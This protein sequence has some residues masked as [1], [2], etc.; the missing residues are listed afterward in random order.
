[1][2]SKNSTRHRGL[3]YL[4]P[5]FVG[6]DV[7]GSQQSGGAMAQ[8]FPQRELERYLAGSQTPG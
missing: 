8:D 2:N 4:G 3:V 1:M 7:E 5:A 6:Q